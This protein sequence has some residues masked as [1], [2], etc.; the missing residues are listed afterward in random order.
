MK[1]FQFSLGKLL[2]FK[3]QILKREKNDLAGLRKQLLQVEEEKAENERKLKETNENFVAAQKT[4]MTSQHMIYTKNYMNMLIRNNEMFDKIIRSIN[5]EIERQ[6][7]IVVEAT[8]EV[9]SIE[10]L[11]EKQLEEYKKEDQKAEELFISEYVQS[12][13]FYSNH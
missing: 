6:L 13:T 5:G 12:S 9:S 2:N 1:K 4:G 10:K 11:K 3:E 7:G 8:K